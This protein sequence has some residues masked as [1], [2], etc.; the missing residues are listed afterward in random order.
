[1]LK[2]WDK[3]RKRDKLYLVIRTCIKPTNKLVS[4]HSGTLSTR[5]SRDSPQPGL[6]GSHHLP[7]YS[8]LCVTPWHVHPNSTFSR[9]SRIGVPK[10]SWFGLPELW[11]FITLFLEFR[12]RW[13]LKKTCSSPQELSNGMLHFTCTHRGRVSSRLLMVES[14]ITSLTLGPSF[15]HNL[16]CRCPNGSCKSIFD[17]Y[18]SKLFQQHKKHIKARCFDPYNR[19]LNFQDSLR[20]PKFPSRECECHPHIPS[21]WGCDIA[22]LYIFK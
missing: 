18:T 22:S 14:Q 5:D 17:I 2:F 12:L 10:L 9:D 8:I 20:T 1:V 3:I 4:S 7:P 19:P 16:C 11:K 6:E 21:K 15:V 13:G